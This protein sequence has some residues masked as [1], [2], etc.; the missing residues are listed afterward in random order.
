[1][2]PD[3]AVKDKCNTG[4]SGDNQHIV[5]WSLMCEDFTTEE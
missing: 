1:M 4:I 3:V 2:I 5:G